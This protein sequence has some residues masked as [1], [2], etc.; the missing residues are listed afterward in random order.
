LFLIILGIVFALGS[1]FCILGFQDSFIQLWWSIFF[2]Y[3]INLNI[4]SLN[5]LSGCI[6]FNFQLIIIFLISL[7]FFCF[8]LSLWLLFMLHNWN[9]VFTINQNRFESVG[10]NIIFALN[11]YYLGLLFFILWLLCLI[12]W[13]WRFWL[14]LLWLFIINS[15]W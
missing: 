1:I 9:V 2:I 6:L 12:F 4:L 5:I 13:D 10:W 7:M 3:C 14:F 8:I 15:D 11:S